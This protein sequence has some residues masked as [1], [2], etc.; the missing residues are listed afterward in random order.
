MKINENKCGECKIKSGAVSILNKDEIDI[1]EN[2]CSHIDFNKGELIFKEG[3]PS[4]NIVFVRDGFIKLC[5]KVTA[6]R[7]FILSIAKRGAYLGIQ[8]LNRKKGEYYF[9]A[10]AITEAKVCFINI[11]SFN[12]LLKRN[13]IFASEIISYIF[14]DEMNY[15]DRLI[16]NIQQQLPGRLANALFYFRDSIY[17][18]N[19]FNINLTKSELASLIG[20]S[21][22]SV[23]RILKEF[24][25]AGI[26]KMERSKITILDEERLKEIKEKG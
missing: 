20:T 16:N 5:K 24:Q 4:N 25:V 23:S 1:L 10:V 11:E 17:D 6:N 22:E 2:A 15:F 21:R 3:T 18:V 14:T 26:I 12:I 8:N 7:D 13:G 9:S 19:P